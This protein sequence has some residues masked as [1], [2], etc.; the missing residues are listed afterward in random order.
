MPVAIHIEPDN[1]VVTFECDGRIVIDDVRAAFQGMFADPGFQPGINALWDLRRA[2]IG[3]R[4]QEIPDLLSMISER[5]SE[6]GQ[7]Y[8][9]AIVVAGSPDFGLSTMFEMSAHSMPFAVRVFR[10]YT[11]ATKWLGGEDV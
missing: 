2:S 7:D 9:V 10:S 4:M 11:Q 8:R 1:R 6:R 5:Q 3:V